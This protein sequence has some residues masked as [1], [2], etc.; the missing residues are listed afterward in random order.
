MRAR[1]CALITTRDAMCMTIESSLPPL[2][3]C[4]ALRL[5]LSR[6]KRLASYP[7]LRRPHRLLLPFLLL[8]LSKGRCT[9]F[10]WWSWL[11]IRVCLRDRKVREGPVTREFAFLAWLAWPLENRMIVCSW[12]LPRCC[13][14][15]IAHDH[16]K[17]LSR[18]CE[19]HPTTK[20]PLFR[21]RISFLV[22]CSLFSLRAHFCSGV[23]GERWMAVCHLRSP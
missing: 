3:R 13:R 4:S 20:V 8:L 21:G 12:Q 7:P 16:P 22:D 15:S 2:L 1:E 19:I 14:S 5:P 18:E 10:V 23:V 6:Q 17:R 9:P 11:M